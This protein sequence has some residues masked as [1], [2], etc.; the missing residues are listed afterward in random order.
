MGTQIFIELR[1]GV[2][3]FDGN[4][5][6]SSSSPYAAV[7]RVLCNVPAKIEAR[8]N[9]QSRRS[10]YF[11]KLIDSRD[12]V[13]VSD[14]QCLILLDSQKPSVRHLASECKH[15]FISLASQSPQT[16]FHGSADDVAEWW[17][18][19]VLDGLVNNIVLIA[20]GEYVS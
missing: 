18:M 7:H 20:L 12:C 1:E 11:E 2:L 19:R 9:L 10:A 5:F 13:Q 8:I 6:A 16:V 17:I 15:S 14:C 4:C 3:L